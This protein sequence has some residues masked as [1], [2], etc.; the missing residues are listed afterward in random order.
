MKKS[1]ITMIMCGT[2]VSGI[3]ITAHAATSTEIPNEVSTI[4]T[5][6]EIPKSTVSAS[7]TDFYESEQA[8]GINEIHQYIVKNY[9]DNIKLNKDGTIEISNLDKLISDKKFKKEYKNWLTS[10]NFCIKKGSFKF[11][12]M[13]QPE[14]IPL[15]KMDT[16]KRTALFESPVKTNLARV[17]SYAATFDLN[18]AAWRNGQYMAELAAA[19]RP[20]GIPGRASVYATFYQFV[21]NGGPW[22]YKQTLGSTSTYSVTIGGTTFSLTGEQIGNIHYG[23]VGRAAE[24][25]A[26]TLRSAAGA[27]QYAAGTSDP[28]FW[29]SYFDDPRDQV[30]INRGINWRDTYT[31]R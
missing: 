14:F 30:E 31:F 16:E 17:Q 18:G 6:Q 1:I 11:N 25:P 12:N 9:K 22:D 29:S 7:T 26:I 2:L 28:S 15:E 20:L 24:I 5:N 23:Y 13:F 8:K 21:R 4:S 19:A 3:S 10:I 27:A